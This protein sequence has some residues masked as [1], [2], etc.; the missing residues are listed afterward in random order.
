MALTKKQKE[1][2]LDELKTFMKDAKSVVFAKNL[3]LTVSEISDLRKALRETGTKYQ[4]AKKT[5]LKKAA[6]D[7]LDV[8][9]ANEVLDGAVGATFSMEDELTGIKALAKFAKANEKIE[10]V[11]GIFEGKAITKAEAIQLSQIPS[12]EE[13]LAKM[14]GSMQSPLTGF[15][16]VGNQLISGFARVVDGY[17]EQKAASES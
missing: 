7:S 14:L 2:I 1:A 9:V 10:I 16:G 3:G 12:K 13:L 15:V 4:V 17:R 8:E 6:Q 5:L 11:G